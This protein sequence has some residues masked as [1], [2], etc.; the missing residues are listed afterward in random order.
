MHTTFNFNRLVLLLKRFFI[1]NKT[2]ELTYWGIMILVFTVIHNAE[3]VKTILYIMG[4][5]FAAKQYKLFAYTPGGMHYLLIPATHLEKLVCNILLTTVYFFTMFVITYSIGNIVGTNLFNLL[6]GMSN[7][8]SW[9]F[10]NS[11]Y[12]QLMG[13]N[14][15]LIGNN[16]DLPGGNVFL[17]MMVKFLI[18][19]SIFM[20]GSV[21]F[22]HNAIGKTML[23]LISFVIIIGM[24]E[25]FFLKDLFSGVSLGP[26]TH[27]LD[28]F[29]YGFNIFTYLL[30]PFLWIVTYFRLTEKQV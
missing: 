28:N 30:I 5:I 13:G 10:F 16:I 18:V 27:L 20:L 11:S 29:G 7:P 8:V 21:Y 23:T 15:S 4:F 9:N 24:I 19:Q 3:T 17:N 22:K 14:T 26:N 1:E 2:I 25:L 6:N 12:A